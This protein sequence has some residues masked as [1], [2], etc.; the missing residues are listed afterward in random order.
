M[1]QRRKKIRQK[2]LQFL[3]NKCV[4]CGAT[5][6]LEVNHIDRKQK[7]YS[8]AKMYDFKWSE[9]EKELKKCNVLCE[10]CHAAYTSNQW[11]NGEIIPH[12]KGKRRE[13]KHGDLGMYNNRQCRCDLCKNAKRNSR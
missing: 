12:N 1:R 2:I 4:S 11:K 5:S 6:N 9:I 8:I 13:Y 10:A 7:T 3:G